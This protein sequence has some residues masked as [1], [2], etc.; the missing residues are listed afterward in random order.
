[1]ITINFVLLQSPLLSLHDPETTIVSREHRFMRVFLISFDTN[2]IQS[3]RNSVSVRHFQRSFGTSAVTRTMHESPLSRILTSIFVAPR[4]RAHTRPYFSDI[5]FK[6]QAEYLNTTTLSM[7]SSI[8]RPVYF[9]I[10]NTNSES[11][12]T[13][14]C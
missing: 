13:F 4:M 2:I 7:F 1:M 6:T 14:G 11:L 10:P 5:H 12:V 8:G 3:Q 9:F